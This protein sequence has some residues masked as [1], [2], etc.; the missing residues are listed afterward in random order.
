MRDISINLGGYRLTV[1]EPPMPK[2]REDGSPVVDRNG[3]ARFVV[4][5]FVKQLPVPGQRTPKGEEVR[6][7]L[8]TDPGDIAEGEWVELIDPRVNPW[9]IRDE[10][11]G[12]VSSGLAFSALGVKVSS[13][14][15]SI[16][17]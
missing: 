1:V 6:V 11:T 8:A 2:V 14:S 13:Q 7:T 12:R 10:S 16:E 4:S 9:E 15:G 17:K 3:S 5:L